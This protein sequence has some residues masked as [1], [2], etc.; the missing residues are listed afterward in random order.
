[1]RKLSKLLVLLLV[2][3]IAHQGYRKIRPSCVISP[4]VHRH[5]R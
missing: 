2:V 5:A 4:V 3:G 1:M